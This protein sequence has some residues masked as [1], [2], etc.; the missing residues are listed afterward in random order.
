MKKNLFLNNYLMLYKIMIFKNVILIK[1]K[2]DKKLLILFSK[3]KK[4]KILLKN[5]IIRKW[6]ASLKFY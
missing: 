4:N 2:Y 1:I 5:C 6:L 3:I